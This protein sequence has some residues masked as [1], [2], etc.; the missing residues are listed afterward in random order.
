MALLATAALVMSLAQ[1]TA[2]AQELRG[3][4]Q[5]GLV[6]TSAFHW[7]GQNLRIDEQP[8][9][10]T[11]PTNPTPDQM[12]RRVLEGGQIAGVDAAEAARS[13]TA[14]A[15]PMANTPPTVPDAAF[16]SE[17]RA[18]PA[19]T[20]RY[21]WIKDRF[22]WCS[23]WTAYDVTFDP[24]TGFSAMV[25]KMTVIGYGRDDGQRENVL[26]M[27]PEQAAVT[28]KFT[29][30]YRFGFETACTGPTPGCGVQGGTVTKT[31]AEWLV[32]AASGTWTSWKVTSDENAS[33]RQD[34]VL[35]HFFHF[36]AHL[37]G[38]QARPGNYTYATKC[39]SADYIPGRPKGCVFHDVV[40]HL[41][42]R[43]HNPDGSN[44]IVHDVAEHIQFAFDHPD[45]TWPPENHPKKIPGKYTGVLDKDWVDHL[46]R[47]PYGSPDHTANGKEKDRA[48][49]NPAWPDKP[50]AGQ[51]CDE[52]PFATTVQGAAHPYYDFSVRAVSADNN[53]DAGLA[54][55]AY[56]R[57]DR[58]LYYD[59]DFFYVQ[60]LDR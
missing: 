38:G 1:G 42:Y 17:C 20:G 34:K 13:A 6:P 16:V 35:Y 52:F 12:R 25:I 18:N 58:I 8:A 10:P 51:Q 3:W 23:R 36:V 60:I 31:I 54:L 48:C 7:D 49:T 14:G 33:T 30:A 9:A 29:P 21:G 43:V 39:D 11:V 5:K 27:T 53:R 22:H 32:D 15:Q 57:E 41:Q 28:G 45:S 59:L 55:Q 56:Y 47:V 37:A 50:Q 46:E 19:S 26:F 44:S 40:P 4:H 24:R 2:S